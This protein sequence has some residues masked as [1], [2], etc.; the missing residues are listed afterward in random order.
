MTRAAG[1]FL[2][3]ER[4]LTQASLLLACVLL[5]V[6]CVLGL[7]QVVAR[8]V[9]SQPSTWTEE[10]MRRLLIWSVMFGVVAAV[11]RGALVSVDL[12][13]RLSRGRWR[14]L[15]RGIIAT[16]TIA[17]LSVLLWHGVDL[18]WRVRFQT[19]ASLD[20]ISMSWGYAAIPVGA[21]LSMVAMIGQVLD[22]LDE[23]LENAT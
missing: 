5:A 1:A 20:A 15:V 18:V 8:F 12:M 4:R 7:W 19:F 10:A 6:V 23:E 21:A 17:F 11:R 9:L 14:S 3:F 2:A 22:P 13:L 16:S